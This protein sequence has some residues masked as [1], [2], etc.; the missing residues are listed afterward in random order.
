MARR[1]YSVAE[2]EA[3]IPTLERTF[4]QVMQLRTGLRG[5][6]QKLS[7]AGVRVDPDEEAPPENEPLEVRR[8]RAVFRGYYEALSDELERIRALG[9]E[10]KDLDAGLVDFP[11]RRGGEEILLCWRLGEKRIEYWHTVEGGFAGRRPLD[12]QIPRT[13]P[14]LD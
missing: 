6:E 8:A 4:V 2:V 10:V 12:E 9:G 3:L 7:Q 13:P 11:G 1:Y 14:R 5:V